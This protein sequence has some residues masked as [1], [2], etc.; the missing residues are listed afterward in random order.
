M[1]TFPLNKFGCFECTSVMNII[2]HLGKWIASLNGWDMIFSVNWRLCLYFRI[3]WSDTTSSWAS[4]FH[5]LALTEKEEHHYCFGCLIAKAGCLRMYVCLCAGHI[6][7]FVYWRLVFFLPKLCNS[8]VRS[9]LI[10]NTG[11]YLNL[12]V[13]V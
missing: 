6:F 9:C 10:S 1:I 3:S 2:L 11:K 7:F 12:T 8:R 5:F 4:K 13:S